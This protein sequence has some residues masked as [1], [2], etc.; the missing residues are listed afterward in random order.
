M[1]AS[2]AQL[3]ECSTGPSCSKLTASL[4]NDSLKFTSSETQIFWNF[5]LKKCA[6]QKLLTFFQ[7]KISR[8]L[9]IESAKIVNEMALN[10]LVKLATLWTTRPWWSGGCRII[11]SFVSH[12]SFVEFFFFIWVLWPFQE[13]FTYVEP[14]VHQR[15][16]KTWEPREKP[17]D[18]P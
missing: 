3:D 14:I 1:T 6:V 4:V 5:L 10:E 17:P 11:H 13:Y 16:V 15:W 2:V 9:Y 8:K 18:H 7:Q 12:Y